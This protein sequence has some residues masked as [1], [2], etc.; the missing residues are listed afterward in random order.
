MLRICT[1]ALV[2]CASLLAQ[3]S[4]V[5]EAP[6]VSF[7]VAHEPRLIREI[8]PN[9]LVLL[10][11]PDPRL[12]LI[13]ARVDY[14]V[15]SRNEGPGTTGRAHLLEHMMF[16]GT[17]SNGPGEFDRAIEGLGG[18]ANAVTDRDMTTYFT[19]LAR[20][21]LE[22]FLQLEADRMQ[23]LRFVP[24]RIATEMG[25]IAQE[26]KEGL[27]DDPY[28]QGAAA[29][30]AHLFPDHPYRWP[31]FG[32]KDDVFGTRPADLWRFYRRH[33]GPNNA[34]VTLVGDF[35]P[36]A[37]LEL[38]RREFAGLAPIPTPPRVVAGG[39]APEHEALVRV[40]RD[41]RNP[42]LLM[43]FRGLRGT[44]D[45][46]RVSELLAELLVNGPGSRLRNRLIRD[47][48]VAWSIRLRHDWTIDPEAFVIRVG[49]YENVD[50]MRVREMVFEEIGRI[51]RE[52]VSPEVL[53]GLALQRRARFWRGRASRLAGR[54]EL[55]AQ[56]EVLV[57]SEPLA[58]WRI[59]AQLEDVT[60]EEIRS[61]AERILVRERSVSV[62][63]QSGE[64]R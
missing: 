16:L 45:E 4:E 31:I 25:V 24:E 56:G 37:A 34:V 62:I 51:G 57:G 20:E 26:R 43:G 5:P 33:Y 7:G 54:G 52:S 47:E 50:P 61:L 41:V 36:I 53:R 32:W 29:V 42:E 38:V 35:E 3:T 59:S 27:D 30:F 49:L 39:Q 58:P 1:S 44:D 22:R 9:G 17:G 15:G 10:L 28:E 14:R 2:L 60:A 55:L 18:K 21:G 19:V 12:P 6:R 40:R 13:A 64:S 48:R 46:F 63:V 23:D 8:L 11:A